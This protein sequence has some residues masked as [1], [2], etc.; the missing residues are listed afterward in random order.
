MTAAPEAADRVRRG[1]AAW[2]RAAIALATR[3]LGLAAPNPSVGALVVREGIVVGRGVTA[4]GGR[5][6]AERLALAQAGDLARGATVYVTLEPCAMRS[7]RAD[8]AACTDLLV[9]AGVARVVIGADDPSPHASQAGLARL[10]AA[11][12]EIRRG[13]L[14]AECRRLTLGHVLRMVEGRPFV[15]VKLAMTAD[16]FAGTAARGPLAITGPH[17]RDRA[18][19]MRAMADAVITGVGTVVADD[20]ALTCRLP[21]MAA[22][23]PV[24]VVLDSRLRTPPSAGLVL[25]AREVPVWIVTTEG[26]DI[27]AE[28]ALRRAG[29]EVMRVRADRSGRVDAAGA[30]RL[31]ATRGVTRVMAEAGPTLA[32]TLAGLDLIDELALFRS[33]RAAGAGIPALLPP[34]RNWLDVIP[35]ARHIPLPE[36]ETL[37]IH[38]RLR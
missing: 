16:G 37:A 19:M 24:R 15:L 36:G 17:A 30:L 29:V 35:A 23:S 25:G 5:P 2:M 22:R 33:P 18:H 8:A 20:P 38:E 4:P 13:M 26:A 31:L 7:Q 6:H 11:G 3:G 28:R 21:G 27:E 34:L 10:A 12:I 32:A 14:A 9:A 1:D